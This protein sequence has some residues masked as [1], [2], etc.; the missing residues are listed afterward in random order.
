MENARLPASAQPSPVYPYPEWDNSSVKNG[1][2][3]ET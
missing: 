1:D 2:E 3:E